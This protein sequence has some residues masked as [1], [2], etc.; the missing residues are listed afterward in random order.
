[1]RLLEMKPLLRPYSGKQLSIKKRIFNYRLSRARRNVEISFGILSNKWRIF[2]RPLNV[3]IDFAVDIVKAC[4]ILH[5][6]VRKRDG[7]DYEDTLSFA[8]DFVP[9][10]NNFDY[11][12]GRT[13]NSVR[14]KYAD[15][16]VSTEGELPWQYKNA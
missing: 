4:T 3:S 8:T 6:I 16:F 12:V 7:Y 1:M 2:H 11:R 5:N 15:Y 13:V 14:D 9:F 10:E